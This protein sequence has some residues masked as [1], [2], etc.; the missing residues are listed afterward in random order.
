MQPF[1]LLLGAVPQID[2]QVHPMLG[3]TLAAAVEL[4][5]AEAPVV[6]VAALAHAV[7]QQGV[8]AQVE[9]VAAVEP[10]IDV[11]VPELDA[12]GSRIASSF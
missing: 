4:L 5:V 3:A 7:A 6:V 10:P 11:G 9:V 1:A 12:F 2:V 8:A